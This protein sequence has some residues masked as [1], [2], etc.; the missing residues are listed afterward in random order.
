MCIILLS[1]HRA[2]PF[3]TYEYI[4]TFIDCFLNQMFCNVFLFIVLIFVGFEYQDWIEGSREEMTK[5]FPQHKAIIE[6]LT[7]SDNDKQSS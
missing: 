1:T 2:T 5:E 7:D 4:E 3:E 6:K